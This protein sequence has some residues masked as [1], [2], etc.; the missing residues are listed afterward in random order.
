LGRW[1]WLLPVPD[2]DLALVDATAEVLGVPAVTELVPARA[3]PW[4][5]SSA[6]VEIADL[7]A[8][9]RTLGRDGHGAVVL[10]DAER[11]LAA[12]EVLGAARTSHGDEKHERREDQAETLHDGLQYSVFLSPN[13]RCSGRWAVSTLP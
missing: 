2:G 1:F 7:A 13:P 11:L 9:G 3:V 10:A 4:D 6:L 5:A 12:V 8:V